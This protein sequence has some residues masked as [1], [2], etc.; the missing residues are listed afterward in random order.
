VSRKYPKLCSWG[1]A[2]AAAFALSHAPPL[3]RVLAVFDGGLGA[4]ALLA[5]PGLPAVPPSYVFR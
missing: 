2:F 4:G 1:A 5:A 3:A